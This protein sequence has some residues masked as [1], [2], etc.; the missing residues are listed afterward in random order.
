MQNAIEM[1]KH[2]T[3][4]YGAVAKAIGAEPHIAAVEVFFLLNNI[5]LRAISGINSLPVQMRQKICKNIRQKEN[6]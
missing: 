3:G 2:Q 1:A 5:R 6:R 4:G